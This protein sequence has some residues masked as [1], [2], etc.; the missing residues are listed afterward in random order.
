[1]P[2]PLLLHVDSLLQRCVYRTVAKQWAWRGPTENTACNISFIF[3]WHH[4]IH[5]AFLC[6]VYMGHYLAIAVSLVP[7]FLLWANTPQYSYCTL[8]VFL[9]DSIQDGPSRKRPVGG[10]GAIAFGNGHSTREIQFWQ[11]PLHVYPIRLWLL[12]VFAWHW[13]LQS[14]QV[15]LKDCWYRHSSGKEHHIVM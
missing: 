11:V 1:M 8:H 9:L 14:M 7:Q 12:T 13:P 3:V 5:D 4:R 6:C 15:H 10:T 2:L